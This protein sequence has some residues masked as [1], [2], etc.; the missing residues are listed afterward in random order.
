MIV[1]VQA[2]S[3]LGGIFKTVVLF[4]F[5]DNYLIIAEHATLAPELPEGCVV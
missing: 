4:F 2:V 3:P 5:Q 1:F